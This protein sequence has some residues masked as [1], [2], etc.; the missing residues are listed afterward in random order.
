MPLKSYHCPGLVSP[1]CGIRAA[2]GRCVPGRVASRDERWVFWDECSGMGSSEQ[3]SLGLAEPPGS[4]CMNTK[5]R[6][7]GA[8]AQGVVLCALASVSAAGP[9]A[10]GI[11]ANGAARYERMARLEQYLMNP[12]AEIA[13][14]RSA[15]PAAI[16]DKATIL[17]LKPQGY[18]TA[19]NG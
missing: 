2:A 6:C 19:A 13:L 3:D 16:S 17:A 7:A 5:Y 18:E 9:P 15:A 11:S 14:A 12:S 10:P 1:R 4:V 8:L